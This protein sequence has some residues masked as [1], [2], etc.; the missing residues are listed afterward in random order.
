[1][2]LVLL[3]QMITSLLGM[4]A[5]RQIIPNAAGSWTVSPAAAGEHHC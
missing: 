1:M 5:R 2:M 4:L 3:P